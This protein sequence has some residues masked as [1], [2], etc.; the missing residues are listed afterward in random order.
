MLDTRTIELTLP[1]GVDLEAV[2]IDALEPDAMRAVLH[3]VF[4]C[5]EQDRHDAVALLADLKKGGWTVHQGLTWVAS[6]ERGEYAERVSAPS[7]C[8]AVARLREY[9]LL[10]DAEGT[11]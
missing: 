11:P 8:E 3:A 9:V 2:D 1:A 5:D 10:H 6:A 7:R 4:N